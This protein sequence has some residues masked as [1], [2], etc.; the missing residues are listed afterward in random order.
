M[1]VAEVSV[2][3]SEQQHL[4]LDVFV[5]PGRAGAAV[6]S[7]QSPVSPKV[8]GL[9]PVASLCQPFPSLTQDRLCPWARAKDASSH[10]LPVHPQAA[11]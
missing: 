6:G 5:F 7:E 1:A 9:L 11:M 10:S 3:G 2:S 8:L 4:R